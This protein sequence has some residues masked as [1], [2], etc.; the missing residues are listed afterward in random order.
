MKLSVVIPVYRVED[1]LDRCVASVT[2]QNVAEMEVILVDD[3]SPDKCPEM[4][5]EWARRDKRIRVIHKENGGLSDARNAGI[6]VATGDCITFVDSDD[7]LELDTYPAL[8][9]RMKDCE[10]LEYSVAGRLTLKDREYDDAERYWLEGQAYTHTYAWNKLYRR[11]LF[12]NVRYPKGRVFEDVCTLPKLLRQARRVV[13]T[14]CGYYHYSRN[15]QGI[16]AKADGRQ[17]NM[18][19]EGHLNSGMP[20]DDQYYMHLVNIQMDVWEA[21]GEPLKLSYRKV[22]TK[23]FKG[24]MKTKAIFYNILGIKTLCRISKY[25]HQ[26]RKPTPW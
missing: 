10:I 15:P 3:G 9:P 20:M 4:C 12:D 8:L 25:I 23:S 14:A 24:R 26:F 6:D 19:L 18:L 7:W 16:S 2:A 11:E 22:N 17:L 21:T 13:T 5:D 1:T